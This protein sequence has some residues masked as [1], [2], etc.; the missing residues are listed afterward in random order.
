MAHLHRPPTPGRLRRLTEEL[1]EV[2]FELDRED[3]VDQVVLAEIDLAL[4][5]PVHERRVP[6]LGA[7]VDP[8]SPEETWEPGTELSIAH[9]PINQPLLDARRFADGLSSWLIRRPDGPD[10]W[11]VFDR[12]AGSERDLVV[13]S[14]VMAATNV[15]RHPTGAVR[16]VGPHGVLRW[17]GLSW[18]LEPP[19]AGWI[20]SLRAG[21]HEGDAAVLSALIEFAVHDL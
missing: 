16:V 10:E 3:P 18:R 1:G 13:L 2:G 6:S 14:T 19:I 5:P 9:G 21:G 17:D 12:S 8:S 15:Q 11:C 20:A 4:R 7:I